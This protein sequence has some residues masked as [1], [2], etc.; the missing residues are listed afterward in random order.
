[1][2]RRRVA[3]RSCPDPVPWRDVL[4][5]HPAAAELFPRHIVA[6]DRAAMVTIALIQIIGTAP[7]SE[8]RQAVENYLR[9]EL[10]DVARSILTEIRHEDE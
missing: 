10:S 6:R 2:N 1:M 7:Q 4:Q 5:I 3:E 9:D 8:W